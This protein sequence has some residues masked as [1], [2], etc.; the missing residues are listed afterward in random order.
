M[1]NL[2]SIQKAV[3]RRGSIKLCKYTAY[4]CY[5]AEQSI[6]FAPFA[7]QQTTELRRELFIILHAKKKG[8]TCTK[9]VWCLSHLKTLRS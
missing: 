2:Y 9:G 3:K 5:S 7:A 8:T 4:L 6:V 1:V